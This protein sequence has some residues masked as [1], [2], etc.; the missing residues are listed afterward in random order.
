MEMT[1]VYVAAYFGLEGAIIGLLNNGRDTGKAD[2]D[3]KDSYGRTPLWWAARNGHE[4][5][6]KLL[7]ET[8]EVDVECKDENDWTP[9]SWA[10][11][12]GHEAIVKLLLKA[13]AKA[14]CEYSVRVSKLALS[15]VYTSVKLIANPSVFGCYRV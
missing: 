3:S 12:G 6:V 9:L 2:V 15:L 7:L 8:G 13:G 10:I 1:G 5:V 11:E 14:N 4:A